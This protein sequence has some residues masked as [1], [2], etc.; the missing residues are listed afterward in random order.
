MRLEV[1]ARVGSRLLRLGAGPLIFLLC[2][3]SGA[4]I[5]FASPSTSV[6]VDGQRYDCAVRT[7]AQTVPAPQPPTGSN[8]LAESLLS[9]HSICPAG[10][11][12]AP[13]PILAP[14]PA[15]PGSGALRVAGPIAGRRTQAGRILPPEGPIEQ[16][17]AD[18]FYAV[19]GQS[20]P[21]SDG[22]T[23]LEGNVTSQQDYIDHREPGE[24]TIAQIWAI[25]ELP[26]YT[27]YSDV[28]FGWVNQGFEAGDLAPSLFV[29]HFDDGMSTCYNACGFV[30][31]SNSVGHVVGYPISDA[32]SLFTV[33][34]AHRYQ[35]YEEA[36]NWY[37]AID[38]E[39]VG[40]YPSSAWTHEP[41][42]ELTLEEAG[43]EISSATTNPQ[44]QTTMGDGI[45]G[46][47]EGSA[48]WSEL[49][50]RSQGSLRAVNFVT[51]GEN[52]PAAY[53]VGAPGGSSFRYGG[54]G[55][56]SQGSPGYCVPQAT[57]QAASSVT[58]SDAMLLGAVNPEGHPSECEFEFGTTSSYGFKA[59]CASPPGN[60]SG[61]V[62][63]SAPVTGLAA[64]TVYHFRLVATNT[65][66]IGYGTDQTLTTSSP[67]TPFQ[68]GPASAGTSPS[69]GVLSATEH[70]TPPAPAAGLASTSL[71]AS[72]SGT[73][74]VKVSCPAGVTVCV[75]KI[76]LRTLTAT[77]A[78]KGR[79]SKKPKAAILT[80]AAGTF[81]LAGGRATTVKL[82]LTAVAR[83]LL[84]RTR[85]LRARATIVAPEPA[86]AAHTTQT[87]VAIR[88][89]RR[90]HRG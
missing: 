89:A 73:V 56:C 75:G 84:A 43:G 24:H 23:A 72:S 57:T 31:V 44:P 70:R 42:T 14:P 13:R 8:D 17:G 81:T 82:H 41:L 87:T 32:A 69:Q 53:S 65:S 9:P 46:V 48:Y 51:K 47:S 35:V 80:L 27:S 30:Q 50:D 12:P 11:V 68:Q 86:G 25:G 29:Y 45:A 5:A 37:V 7:R 3:V 33:G 10:Q 62:G 64:G 2:S 39:V 90:T 76:T 22:V 16:F 49:K 85:V 19:Q 71:S 28:E 88:A 61:E 55:W 34:P 60:G 6:T 26:G 20:V 63:V 77:A 38:G 74:S 15:P 58:S 4:P 54:P 36:T 83:T 79:Q 52:T 59:P 66:G 67:P 78:T 1:A 40:Y 18:Y 21:E